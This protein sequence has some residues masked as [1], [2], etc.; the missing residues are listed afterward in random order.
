M[1]DNPTYEQLVQ[2]VRDLE[3][4]AARCKQA[5]ELVL[6][7]EK[8]FSSAILATSG[9]L[10]VVLDQG[11]RIVRIN[12][13]CERLTG[14]CL[15]EVKGVPFW[16]VFLIPE[17]VE[18]VKAVFAALRSGQFPSKHE[19]DVVA[20]GGGRFR[21]MW[22]N[23]A[24]L[25]DSGEV[26]YVVGTGIDISERKKAEQALRE[27]EERYRRITEAVTDYVYTVI[28]KDGRPIETV[29]GP[30]CEAVTGYTQKDFLKNPYLWIQMVPEQ[31]RQLVE[32]QAELLLAGVRAEPIE[33][34]IV[35]KE[36]FVRW[37]RNTTVP[38]FDEGGRLVSYE[39]LLKDIT[40]EKKAEEA[41][42]ES[43]ANYRLLFSAG[44]DAIIIVDGATKKIVDANKAALRLY[45]YD[46]DA[47]LQLGVTEIS[48]EPEKS[49]ARIEL[50]TSGKP[51]V[52][53]LNPV[54][55]YHRRKDDTIFP[56][57]VSSGVYTLRDRKFVCA[58]IRD[59]TERMHIE[60][61]LKRSLKELGT[62]MRQQTGELVMANEKLKREIVDRK[63]VE[64]GLLESEEKLYDDENRMGLLQFA[65]EV[66]LN[67]MH[68]LRNPL[69]SIGGFSR[70]IYEGSYG[71]D[72]LKEYA[73][74]IFDESVKLENVL[75]KLLS[76]LKKTAENG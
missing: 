41:L 47:F 51:S 18:S 2:K 69:V 71:E 56:V 21:I 55:R 24:L 75:D 45:G 62:Q 40:D 73:K 23:T 59:I 44:S 7:A 33:H 48:D 37:V 28:V 15:E 6:R 14:Y 63:Q 9:A 32:D 66:A 67:L 26:E 17:E 72:K 61:A 74:F 58:I 36:G 60:E 3:L 10:I 68:E 46:R 54:L 27:S 49:S 12:A 39:G 20:K 16:D 76:H 70:R 52:T 31:D 38:H 35:R 8:D 29:H 4:E 43:E 53:S 1:L 64:R 13:S 19:N 34:R 22:A 5:S 42:L 25:D 50:V 11:G 65:N 57:E 30:S